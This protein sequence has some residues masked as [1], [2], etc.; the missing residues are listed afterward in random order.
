[1]PI[2]D[3]PSYPITMQE[4]I[5]HWIDV[6]AFF[7]GTP[8]TDLKLKGGYLLSQFTTDRTTLDTI[9]V[10]IASD[11]T[12]ELALADRDLKKLSLRTRLTQFRGSVEQLLADTKYES[13]LPKMPNHKADEGDYL[14]PFQDMVDLWNK[15]NAEVT[16]L[17]FTPPITLQAG[18]AVATFTTELGVLRASY[19]A[20]GAAENNLK[21]ARPDRDRQM[22]SA[23]ERMRQYRAAIEAQFAAGDPLLVSLPQLW[24][25]PGPV[26]EP[27]VLSGFWNTATLM[28]DL[29]WTESTDA[30]LGHYSVRYSAEFPY[31]PATEVQLS[32]VLPP[33]LTFSTDQGLT[34]P[35]FTSLFCV[36]VVRTTGAEAGSNILE[37]HRP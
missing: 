16:I 22:R 20:V 2:S 24:P 27:V 36:Y 33:V 30:N 26:L 10:F 11:N 6:N 31:N 34:A 35:T 17:G 32:T 1:M 7:G 8:A 13:A 21:L 5:E 12:L 4:F 18:Y 25:G 28:A 3:L 29:N 15:I 37:V 23:V 14:R 9:I 19:D